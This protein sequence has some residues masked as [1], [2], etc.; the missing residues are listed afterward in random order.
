MF[1]SSGIFKRE[2]VGSPLT[3]TRK[4]K[5]TIM[6]RKAWI[7]QARPRKD[8]KKNW[9]VRW[10]DS[11]GREKSKTLGTSRRKAEKFRL[12]KEN[13]LND[14]ATRSL[15]RVRWKSFREKFRQYK[16][17]TTASSTVVAYEQTLDIFEGQAI[18]GNPII[19][20]ITSYTV[21]KF[22]LA[23]LQEVKAPTV[24]R[25]RR[26]LKVAFGWAMEQNYIRINPVKIKKFRTDRSPMRILN[27]DEIRAVRDSIERD[28]FRV[29]FIILCETGMRIAECANLEF[30]DVNFQTGEVLIQPKAEWTTKNRSYRVAYLTKK[31]LK[32]LESL[33]SE[34]HGNRIFQS[35]PGRAKRS[36]YDELKSAMAK[37][38]VRHFTFHDL[39]KTV[40][41]T[42]AASG[43]N[44][45]VV[46]KLA[47]H[48]DIHTT[49][50]YYTSLEDREVKKVLENLPWTNS[51][52][53][54]GKN[55]QHSRGGQ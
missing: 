52:Q 10:Y 36:F 3:T 27:P 5:E 47:G 28:A 29:M 50:K 41:T 55:R 19:D 14:P 46:Q 2:M 9:M 15:E 53:K 1:K 7:A 37:A 13:E 32:M 38:R 34:V 21:E 44:E 26:T 40:I 16:K 25:D 54:S 17:A 42:L 8:G 12:A 39:R 18:F 23:R 11:Q 24:N 33:K 22:L 51:E 30:S 45:A 48:Q 20:E 6:H 4:G 35:E 31:T 49:L 43:M